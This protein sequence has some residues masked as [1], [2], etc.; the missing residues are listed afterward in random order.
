MLDGK[1]LTVP[2]PVLWLGT[3]EWRH[4]GLTT[5]VVG[6]GMDGRKRVLSVRPGSVRDERLAREV[7]VGSG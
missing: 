5:V 1:P 7:L 6:V 2:C 3:R 4:A